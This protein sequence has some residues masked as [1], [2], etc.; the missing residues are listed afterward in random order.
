MTT[1]L[2]EHYPVPPNK[3][4]IRNINNVPLHGNELGPLEVGSQKNYF[5]LAKILPQKSANISIRDVWTVLN[6]IL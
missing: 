5:L 2:S 4:V 1:F 3:P 6:L